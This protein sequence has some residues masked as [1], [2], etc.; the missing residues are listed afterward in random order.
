MI[1]DSGK[2]QTHFTTKEYDFAYMVKR[3]TCLPSV[4]SMFRSSII[5][6]VGYRDT[7]FRWLGDF[8]YWLRIGLAG[9]MA[10][11]PK[12]LATW[13]YHDGQASGQKSDARA[14]E[15]VEVIEKFYGFLHDRTYQNEMFIMPRTEDLISR[16]EIAIIYL[17]FHN[18]EARCW[19]H[20]VAAAVCESRSEVIRHV[21]EAFKVNPKMVFDLTCVK[22]VVRRARYYIKRR[23]VA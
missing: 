12:T 22:A 5:Q 15:H 17:L 10:R 21:W 11:V 23:L 8:D 9:D 16:I 6:T 2:V 14:N 18:W 20:L 19:S 7:S 4:G 13:R 3:H 1:D